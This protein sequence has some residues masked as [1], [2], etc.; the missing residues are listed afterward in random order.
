MKI[1]EI[2]QGD[3]I[4]HEERFRA[5]TGT[6]LESALGACYSAAKDQWVL[7]GKTWEFSGD[8]LVCIKE[9]QQTKASRDKQE[10]LLLELVSEYQSELEI[11]DF[12][13]A[14][15]ERGNDLEPFSVKAASERHKVNFV[16]CG[17]L[18]SETIPSFKFSPDAIYFNKDG[19]ITG[20]YETKSKAGKKHIE[21]IMKDKVPSEH[22]LQCLCPMIMDDCV[23][24]WVF[25]HFDDRNKI[26]NL[27]TKLN[28]KITRNSYKKLELFLLHFLKS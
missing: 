19:V 8:K 27:F 26:N 22:L 2:K 4:W 25:G 16:T 20:G 23:K 14:D 1:I 28:G 13:S 17:M 24:W 18:Q 11:N 10:T 12:C 6:K 5:V 3:D 15:M 7:G 21:Y 9:S